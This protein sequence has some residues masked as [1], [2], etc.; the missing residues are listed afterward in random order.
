[1]TGKV[2]DT[3]LTLYN[4]KTKTIPGTNDKII[5]IGISKSFVRVKIGDISKNIYRGPSEIV[6]KYDVDVTK[7][8]YNRLPIRRY[9][10]F[11]I[12]EI[13]F[14]VPDLP[15]EPSDFGEV[16][17]ATCGSAQGTYQDSLTDTEIINNRVVMKSNDPVLCDK[18]SFLAS[19]LSLNFINDIST[20]TWRCMCMSYVRNNIR[21]EP[22]T[23]CFAFE[24]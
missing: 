5:V 19:P 17:E 7:I 9:V 22:R 21:V 2:I 16:C 15:D 3:K 23:N 24:K 8:Y 12:S 20:W 13:N 6:G 14:D 11:E 18:G 10:N 4:G 1:M